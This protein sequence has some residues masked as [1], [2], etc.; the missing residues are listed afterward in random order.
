M[1]KVRGR[2]KVNRP[3]FFMDVNGER[4]EFPAQGEGQAELEGHPLN[5]Y[6]V[7]VRGGAI[8]E[9]PLEDEEPT[10]EPVEPKVESETTETETVD[11]PSVDETNEA[12]EVPDVAALRAR[13]VELFEK[14]PFFGWGADELAKRIAEKEAE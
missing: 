1:V 5:V 4:A 14:Q 13:Y 10:V 2:V 11:T 6:L 3:F 7:Q 12:P 8:E 9:L